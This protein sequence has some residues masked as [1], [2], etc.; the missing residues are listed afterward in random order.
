MILQLI[1]STN[2]DVLGLLLFIFLIIYFI[3]VDDKTI[4][5]YL[6]LFGCIIGF[7]VD[8]YI[9]IKTIKKF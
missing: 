2:G 9:T 3:S 4:I 1:K 5:E 6:L 8:L 7:I